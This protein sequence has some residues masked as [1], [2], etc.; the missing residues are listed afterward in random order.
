M[1][2]LPKW[3][4]AATATSGSVGSAQLKSHHSAR[5]S[6]EQE[7]EGTDILTVSYAMISAAPRRRGL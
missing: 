6:L 1:T 2:E 4:G 7:Q 5:V 3:H